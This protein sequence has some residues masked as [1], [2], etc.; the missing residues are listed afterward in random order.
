MKD[1][2]ARLARCFLAVFPELGSEQ[3]LDAA[4]GTTPGWDSLRMLMLI[5][6]VEEAFELTIP[7]SAYPELLSYGA[8]R[9]YLDASAAGST[10]PKVGTDRSGVAGSGGDE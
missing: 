4:A 10:G 2:D 8:A 5:A 9:A 7:T 6:V 3:V 1:L